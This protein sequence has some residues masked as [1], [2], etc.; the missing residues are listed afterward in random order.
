MPLGCAG[1]LRR[2]VHDQ[3]LVEVEQHQTGPGQRQDPLSAEPVE[4]EVGELGVR[5]RRVL[6]LQA[7]HDRLG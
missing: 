4:P 5:G 7:E 2:P 1:R 6:P 3:V